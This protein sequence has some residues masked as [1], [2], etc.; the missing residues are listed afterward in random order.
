MV[1]LTASLDLAV[2]PVAGGHIE[3]IAATSSSSSRQTGGSVSAASQN[4]DIKA[5]AAAAKAAAEARGT[6]SAAGTPYKAVGDSKWAKIKGY[7]TFQVGWG[8]QSWLTC[9]GPTWD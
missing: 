9:M 1:N 7:S 4:A 6:R 2:D 8:D 3:T 5:Q